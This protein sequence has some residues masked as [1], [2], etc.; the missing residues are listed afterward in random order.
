MTHDWRKGGRALLECFKIY[1]LNMFLIDV[2]IRGVARPQ[3]E[4]K[5]GV[6]QYLFPY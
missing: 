6:L 4:K 1:R 5:K 2:V 3:K